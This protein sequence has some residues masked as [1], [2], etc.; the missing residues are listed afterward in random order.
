MYKA[1]VTDLDGTLLNGNHD[2]GEYTIEIVKRVIE[3]GIKF[4]IATGRNYLGA[5]EI[6]DKINLEI[7]LITSNGA[8]ILDSKGKEI[9]VNNL[10]DK[11]T[12]KILNMDYKEIDS[13]IIL[14]GYSGGDWFTI[15]DVRDRIKKSFN[16]ERLPSIIDFEEFKSKKFNKI[17]FI[18]KHESLL[19]LEKK[20]KKQLGNKVNMVFVLEHCL[21]L[22][23]KDCNK[24]TAAEFLLKRDGLTLEDAVT[25]GDGYNDYEL[26]KRAG[27]GYIMGNAFY[28]LLEALPKNEV[29]LPNTEEGE[30]RK[31]EEIFLKENNEG[32]K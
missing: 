16:S 20:F 1:V 15:E 5:K 19:K 12:E 30:A 10:K 2:V 8:R 9:Y 24:S 7:P 23:S 25:F 27:K 18:G 11:Y 17:F 32:E 6:M 26:I 31:L 4:Y 3:K 29:I 22:F 14:H 21:E 13:E 28:R